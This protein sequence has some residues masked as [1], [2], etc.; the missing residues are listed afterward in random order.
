MESFLNALASGWLLTVAYII[1]GAWAIVHVLRQRK[2][3]MAMLLWI[4]F[5]ILLPLAGPALYYLLGDPKVERRARKRRRRSAYILRAIA[6]RSRDSAAGE[7]AERASAS[8]LE[9]LDPALKALAR[10]LSKLGDSP[11]TPGNKVEVMSSPQQ[12]CDELLAAFDAAR[13]HIHL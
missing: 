8:A 3:P 13:H 4:A 9:L 12:V 11:L 1:A 6:S 5:F 7:G 10:I 2:E